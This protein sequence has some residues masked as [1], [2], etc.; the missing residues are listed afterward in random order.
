MRVVLMARGRR[1]ESLKID[2]DVDLI[3]N[4]TSTMIRFV[5]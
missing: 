3:E 4:W 2:V 1:E 5:P